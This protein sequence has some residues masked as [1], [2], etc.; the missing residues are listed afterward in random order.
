MKNDELKNTKRRKTLLLTLQLAGGN[1]LLLFLWTLLID[2]L[3]Q[4]GLANFFYRINSNLYYYLMDNKQLIFMISILLNTFFILYHFVSK[5]LDQ[6]EEIYH[7]IDKIIADENHEIRLSESE[8]RFLQ[9]LNEIKYQYLLNKRKAAEEKQ[10]KDDLIVYMAHDLKTPLTSVIG[11]LNLLNDEKDQISQ[12]TQYK[13]INIAL[14]KAK[15]VEQLTNEFFEITRYNLH[16]IELIPDKIDLSML[17]EQ[18]IDECYPMFKEKE[19]QC[20]FHNHNSIWFN[21]DGNQL[22]RAFENLLKNAISYSY[23]HSI[24]DIFMEIRNHDIIIIFQ[25]D[26]QPVSK[27]QLERIFDKFYRMDSSRNSATGGSGLG[28][29]ITKKIIELHHG[30]IKVKYENEQIQFII[31]LPYKKI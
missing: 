6:K 5:E 30:Q 17:I 1:L 24:I 14:D 7:A 10:K 16:D 4:D 13:Y 19:L 2:G 31:H 21:G 22:A 28:L 29:A 27:Q 11:Y 12:Q 9:K 8:S 25:N 15:R 18:L 23:K 20:I 3:L 26:S